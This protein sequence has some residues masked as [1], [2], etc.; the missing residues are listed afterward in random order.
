MKKT[1]TKVLASLLAVLMLAGALP[2]A[3][4]VAEELPEKPEGYNRYYFYQPEEWVNEITDKIGIYWWEGEGACDTWP[5]YVANETDVEGVYYYDVPKDVTLVVWNNAIDGGT[6]DTADIYT[7]ANQTVTVGTE[8]YYEEESYFYPDGTDDFDEMIYVID[9]SMTEVNEYSGK[10]IFRGEWY[11]YY[12]SGEYGFAENKEDADEVYTSRTR[13]LFSDSEIVVDIELVESNVSVYE[14]VNGTMQEDYNYETEEYDEWFYYY[15]YLDDVKLK[16]IYKDGSSEVV[17]IDS[18]DN[19]FR[20]DKFDDQDENHWGVGENYA[21]VEFGDCSVQVP[22]TVKA[23]PIASIELVEDEGLEIEEYSDGYWTDYYDY[24][25]SS[26]VEYFEYNYNLDDVIFKVNYTDGTSEEVGFDAY[27][28]DGYIF[29]YYD[30][31][32]GN[33][34]GVGEHSVTIELMGKTVEVPV[35]IVATSVESI[36]LVDDGNIECDENVDGYWSDYYDYELGSWVDYF[37]YN[38]SLYGVIIKINYADGT[39]EEAFANDLDDCHIVDHQNK[40]PW[41]VGENSFTLKYRG[42]S[43]E[44]PVTVKANTVERIEVSPTSVQLYENADG[45]WSLNYDN[46]IDEW[47]EYFEYV[48]DSGDLQLTIYYTDGTSETATADELDGFYISSDQSEPWQ[49]GN[50]YEFV[51][52]YMAKEAIVEATIVESPVEKIELISG[53]NYKYDFYTDGYFDY[54][55]NNETGEYELYY[56]YYLWQHQDAQIKIYYKDG[57]TKTAYVGDEVDEG[58]YVERISNQDENP[59]KEGKDN[60]LVVTYMDKEVAL[61]VEFNETEVESFKLIGDPLKINENTGGSWDERWDYELEEY[62][63]CYYYDV[64]ELLADREFEIKYKNGETEKVNSD[65]YD[66]CYD[67]E[68]Q[69]YNHWLPDKDNTL[70]V[71]CMGGFALLPVEIVPETPVDPDVPDGPVTPD[72]TTPTDSVVTEPTESTPQVTE[73][74]EEIPTIIITEPTEAA[75][76]T[77]ATEPAEAAPTTMATEPA[78]TT[79][80]T[81][82]SEEVTTAPATFDEPDTTTPDETEPSTGEDTTAPTDPVDKGICGDVTGDGKVNIKDATQIQKYAAKLADFTDAEF[83]CADTNGDGK[84]NVKDATAIQKFVAKFDTGLPIE[85]PVA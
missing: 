24:E 11:Y 6:D 32:Y 81:E 82:P 61:P 35:T 38:Y 55:Y 80:V 13:N 26:R 73:P 79:D 72:T 65:Q 14:N 57:T 67:W 20:Y 48:M 34:W 74:T 18:I 49:A 69:Y 16:L 10:P 75:P 23:N 62:V 45:Y 70:A 22:V 3:S 29:T 28:F 8:Y 56:R 64:Y 84:V 46:D 43:V 76:T 15:Y 2:F 44:V 4:A 50:T 9:L 51:V 5:G 1:L 31:Q 54:W 77:M 83:I 39:S 78:E 47:V 37:R 71:S 53:T 12:G 25:L 7:A 85:K 41:S 68:G 60:S 17:D 63:D 33:P 59:W 52:E 40:N 58:Y 42:A 27:E 36:E 66:F 21:T 19:D 30:D